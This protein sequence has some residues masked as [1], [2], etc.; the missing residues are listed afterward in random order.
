[1]EVCLEIHG[2]RSTQIVRIIVDIVDNFPKIFGHL[3]SKFHIQVYFL[4][5]INKYFGIIKL[6]AKANQKIIIF[7]L[8]FHNFTYI[9]LGGALH[10]IIK[11]IPFN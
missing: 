6:D 9:I 3:L 11:Y 7:I 2:T 4:I 5:K 10:I 8:Y 1:M